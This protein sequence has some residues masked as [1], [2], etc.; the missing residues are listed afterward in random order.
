M[1]FYHYQF[2]DE[3]TSGEERLVL[4]VDAIG[5]LEVMECVFP[6]S[7]F[8]REAAHTLAHG[9]QV[10]GFPR[11]SFQPLDDGSNASQQWACLLETFHYGLFIDH[12]FFFVF[13]V[14]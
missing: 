12:C 10:V 11:D 4:L 1:L 8:L 5:A 14:R 7:A 2:G 9:S 3:I 6:I 13:Y